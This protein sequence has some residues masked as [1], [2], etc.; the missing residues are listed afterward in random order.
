[1]SYQT[2]ITRAPA[3]GVEGMLAD[4]NQVVVQSKVAKTTL[5][6]GRAVRVDTADAFELVTVPTSAAQ[7]TGDATNAPPMGVTLWDTTAPTNPYVQYDPVPVVSVGTMWVICEATTD[8]SLPVYIRH[9]ANGGN[10][11]IGGFSSAA[12]TGLSL[13]PPGFRWMTK[14][15]AT[16]ALAKLAINLP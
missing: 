15:T 7:V 16:G 13:A 5:A 1:M 9:T 14:T 10:T 12:G 4:S 2:S 6:P 11:V 8:P 3:V